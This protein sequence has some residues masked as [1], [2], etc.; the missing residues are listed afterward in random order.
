[1]QRHSSITF[2]NV[3]LCVWVGGGCRFGSHS[4]SILTSFFFAPYILVPSY[5]TATTEIQFM[6]YLRLIR[7]RLKLLNRILVEYRPM[8]RVKKL[9]AIEEVLLG[10]EIDSQRFMDGIGVY[11][12]RGKSKLQFTAPDIIKTSKRVPSR[13]KRWQQLAT[14]TMNWLIKFL[15]KPKF[16]NSGKIYG[17]ATNLFS[18]AEN[19]AKLHEAYA[20]LE[21]A[22]I[23]INSAYSMQLI[24]IL[25]VKF[26]TLTSLLYFCC[27]MIIG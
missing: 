18:D 24:T 21:K 25:I 7:I 14:N 23:L 6:A 8:K 15:V 19:V 11:A 3:T 22:A 27:M 1:M 17:S 10:D 16:A 4:H 20:N 26:T 13:T 12:F 9:S 2:T 5:V